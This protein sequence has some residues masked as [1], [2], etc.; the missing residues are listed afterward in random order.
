MTPVIIY[1]RN[2]IFLNFKD[3]LLKNLYQLQAINAIKFIR[4]NVT[5]V[6][7]NFPDVD[8]SISLAFQKLF[9]QL[10][11]KPFFKH[12]QFRFIVFF[13]FIVQNEYEK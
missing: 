11:L 13:S 2:K 6:I 10:K 7:N 12:F 1:K 3:D 5:P 8:E 9:I 4:K